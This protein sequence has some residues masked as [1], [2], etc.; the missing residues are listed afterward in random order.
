M[1]RILQNKLEALGYLQQHL[2]ELRDI[3]ASNRLELLAYMIE[4][5]YVEASDGVRKS[6]AHDS[7]NST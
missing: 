6:Q 3:A 5:A 4:M 2:R 1:T 7:D